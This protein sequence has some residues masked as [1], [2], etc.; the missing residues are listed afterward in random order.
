MSKIWPGP[1]YINIYINK[2]VLSTAM[3]TIRPASRKDGSQYFS[4]LFRHNGKQPSKSFDTY[5]HADEFK[6]MIKQLGVDKALQVLEM[7]NPEA[8]H[9]TLGDWLDHYLDHKSGVEKSTI[10][11]Y[12][13]MVEKD[14]KPTLGAI[15][16]AAL[17]PEDIA[18]WVM[19]LAERGLAGKTISNKHGFLS[20]ALN[21][22]ATKGHITS[23][24]A[25]G[26]AGLVD[27]PRTEKRE[28]VFLEDD[29]YNAIH[30]AITEYWRPLVE[31]L[32][33]SGCRWGEAT[34]LRPSDINRK[35][36]TVRISRAWKRTYVKGAAYELGAPK[37]DNSRRTIN[38][39][40]VVLDK[41]DFSHEW[42]FV[43]RSGRP[44][45]H[46]GFH[47]RVWQPALRRANLDVTPRVH[48]LRH[49]CASWLIAAG[50]PML[51]VKEHFGHESIKVTYDIY[52][53]LDRRNGQ[54][55]A[56]A[57]AAKLQKGAA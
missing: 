36:G 12:R 52:G 43:N 41:L 33:A 40:A 22:A 11:D 30:D 10:Y 35:A 42:L 14:I 4:V 39:D 13:K 38:V 54:A 8:R 50:L 26:G 6:K 34:A 16:I 28:P 57:I 48:D 31:F 15:P 7:S 45:R 49:T 3:A 24:P 2:T 47:D 29:Q 53:H 19:M 17:T 20:S 37:T 23:N 1:F 5:E 51:A 9:Y 32:I 18:K 21:V 25:I 46:N 27:V 44:V 55:V 56:S